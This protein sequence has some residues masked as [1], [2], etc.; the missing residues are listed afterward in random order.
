MSRTLL[1]GLL[2]TA[3]LLPSTYFYTVFVVTL[4]YLVVRR[5]GKIPVSALR[6]FLPLALLVFGGLVFIDIHSIYG[7]IRDLWYMSKIFFVSLTGLLIGFTGGADPRFTHRSTAVALILGVFNAA[8]AMSGALVEGTRFISYF[9][10]FFAPFILRYYPGRGISA[11]VLRLVIIVPIVGMIVLSGSRAAVLTFLISYLATRGVFQNRSKPL[12]VFAILASLM[13]VIW[14]M[15]PQYDI[16]NITFLGKVQ[17]ALTEVTF[18]TGEDRL[19]MYANWRG[20]EAYRAFETWLNAP[21]PEKVIGSGFGATIDL[22]K[23][24]AYGS[25]EVQS[26]PFVHNAYFTLLVKTG[27]V[28]VVAMVYFLLLPFRIGFDRHDPNEVMLSQMARGA[29][30]TLLGTTVLIAGP[31][32][33]ESLD[34]VLLLWGWSSGVLIRSQCQARARDVR[35]KRVLAAAPDIVTA[36]N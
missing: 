28:G 32:N 1:P 21:F 23:V 12:L 14:P 30:I 18:E 34:G 2:L 10:A 35:A 16:A 9:A 7:S 13:M 24:V 29:A 5:R 17:N 36:G 3:S 27:V 8:Y 31:L 25:D 11:L 15:L 33:K 6:P 4:V 26:L 20:F 22:G 19:E